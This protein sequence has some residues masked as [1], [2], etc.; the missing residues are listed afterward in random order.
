V[1]FPFL[2][3]S[4]ELLNI[5]YACIDWATDPID[6]GTAADLWISVEKKWAMD[7]IDAGAAAEFLE[8]VKW[9]SKA[10]H[11]PAR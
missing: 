2:A 7:H 3:L 9:T 4:V 6:D 5:I 8:V 10:H 1:Y 11:Y